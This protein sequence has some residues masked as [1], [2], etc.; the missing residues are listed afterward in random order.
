VSPTSSEPAANSMLDKITAKAK[1][2]VGGLTG[3]DDL[4]Q[5]GQLQEQKTKA[6][7]VAARLATEADQAEEAAA[8][9]AAEEANR[10]EL[11]RIQAQQDEIERQAQIDRERSAAEADA[12][13]QAAAQKTA[14]T[15]QA[16]LDKALID[17]AEADVAAEH[18]QALKEASQLD[19]E[20]V[21]AREAAEALEGAQTN[22][23]QQGGQS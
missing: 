16:Q 3:N 7:D 17:R 2:V 10:L 22:L 9:A 15:R 19:R 6:A 12:D 20:A 11:Q 23:E 13:R 1:Q 21:R 5:E 14:A 18:T 4:A 8:V